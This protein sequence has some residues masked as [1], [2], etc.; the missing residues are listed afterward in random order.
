ML[1]YNTG[2]ARIYK[3][4]PKFVNLGP[5]PIDEQMPRRSVFWSLLF[6]LCLTVLLISCAVVIALNC[7]P[8]YTW[9]MHRLGLAEASGLSEDT[10]LQN[11][12]I[13]IDYNNLWG[14]R[15]L[16]FPDFA[17]SEA[18]RIH[19][20]EVRTIFLAFEIALPVSF[21]L[22]LL[23]IFLSHLW[24]DPR[25]LKW[26]G[27]F[28]LL[29]PVLLGIGS[30]IDFDRVFVAFHQLVFDNDYWIFDPK[31]DPI[32][33]VLPEEFFFHE[34]LLIFALAVLGAVASLILYGVR[35]RRLAKRR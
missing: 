6:G 32:I 29:L 18:G 9:D 8:L 13:L 30:A 5:L 20:A 2:M 22:V 15:T 25:Y 35:K 11:Y 33:N 23:G 21:V 14:A 31:T 28:T 34:A 17:M 27:I 4:N 10:L 16:E 1:W 19:F 12:R 24:D 26:G 3:G 7:I